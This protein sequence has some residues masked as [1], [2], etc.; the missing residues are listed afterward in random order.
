MSLGKYLLAVGI[1][2]SLCYYYCGVSLGEFLLAVG[3]IILA[4]AIT[5]GGGKDGNGYT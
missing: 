5:C 4:Y 2:L 3:I 1:I